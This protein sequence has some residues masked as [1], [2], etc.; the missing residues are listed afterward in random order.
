VAYPLLRRVV[1]K[2]YVIPFTGVRYEFFILVVGSNNMDSVIC[3]VVLYN[4]FLN[5]NF[6]GFVV[7]DWVILLN[8]PE[9]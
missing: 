9:F 7:L 8:D 4:I 2:I 1:S 5:P 6:G 3:S